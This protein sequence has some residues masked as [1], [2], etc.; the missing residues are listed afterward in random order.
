MSLDDSNESHALLRAH[1]TLAV[2]F[3]AR[4][5]KA[6]PCSV[7]DALSQGSPDSHSRTIVL[8]AHPG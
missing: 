8:H 6:T 5:M 2:A 3:K 4:L 7:L 1:R